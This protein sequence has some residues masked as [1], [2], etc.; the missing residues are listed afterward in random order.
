MSIYTRLMHAVWSN[1]TFCDIPT[2]NSKSDKMCLQNVYINWRK[3]SLWSKSKLLHYIKVS[4]IIYKNTMLIFLEKG[5]LHACLSIV[6]ILCTYT[7]FWH[8]NVKNGCPYLHRVQ[9]WVT[10]PQWR[11][12]LWT[13][14]FACYWCKFIKIPILWT[15]RLFACMLFEALSHIVTFQPAVQKG[16]RCAYKVKGKLNY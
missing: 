10:L 15:F 1:V 16:T 11:K 5:H 9:C 14:H 13:S 3:I 12:D 4:S 7:I 6:F 2:C 8:C